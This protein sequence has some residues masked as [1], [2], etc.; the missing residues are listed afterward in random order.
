MVRISSG[1]GEPSHE[2]G[3]PAVLHHDSKGAAPVHRPYRLSLAAGY[4]SGDVRSCRLGNRIYAAA[5][6]GR[7]LRPV[8]ASTPRV[9]V[10][11]SS[12][13]PAGAS[14]T[15]RR[16]LASSSSSVS[17][18]PSGDNAPTIPIEFGNKYS[19]RHPA[20]ISKTKS[21]PSVPLLPQ[22]TRPPRSRGPTHR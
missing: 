15:V 10:G 6:A 19:T 16:S 22:K 8:L 4:H 18:S 1:F 3:C 17:P 11:V 13:A 20:S 12:M 2:R 21:Q 9:L 5:M 7:L 14:V